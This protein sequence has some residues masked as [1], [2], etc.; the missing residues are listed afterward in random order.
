MRIVK[1]LS[2]FLSFG[3]FRKRGLWLSTVE[4]SK[5]RFN[6]CSKCNF[7]WESKTNSILLKIEILCIVRSP[8]L[9]LTGFFPKKKVII[10]YS[11]RNKTVFFEH[12]ITN[13]NGGRKVVLFFKGDSLQNRSYVLVLLF[14]LRLRA[15]RNQANWLLWRNRYSINLTRW[16]PK[17]IRP[18]IV[19]T[20]SNIPDP[21]K[22]YHTPCSNN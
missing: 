2:V 8:P 21:I 9:L 7:V 6:F 1:K 5:K 19:S 4:C 17:A 3:H 16:T 13:R 15:S 10:F 22:E 20:T 14:S 11:P 12:F 18:Q